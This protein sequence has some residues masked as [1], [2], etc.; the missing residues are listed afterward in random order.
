LSA[1]EQERLARQ[2]RQ[3]AQ[4]NALQPALRYGLNPRGAGI[5]DPSFVHQLVFEPAISFD[6]P[7]TR[8][9]Q[10][11]PSRTSA[12]V[13]LRPRPGLT[14]SQ[15]QAAV[16]LVRNAV[17]SR[18]FRLESS[19]YFVTGEP[20]AAL[21]V[22]DHVS[23]QLL[24]LLVA[25]ILIVTAIV[26]L[27][28]RFTRPLLPLAPAIVTVALTFGLMSL[29]GA[30]LTIASIAVL[31][32]LAG[33]AAGLAIHFQR[34]GELPLVPAAAVAIGFGVLVA[35]PVPMV[36]TFGVFVAI[37]IVLALATTLTLG[38]ALARLLPS[39]EPR[40][41]RRGKSARNLIA[42]VGAGWG[43]AVGFAGRR[44]RTVL[45]LA[46]A[47]ALL[48]WLLAPQSDV[49]SGLGKLASDDV[50]EV[51]ELD[52]LARDA[53]VERGVNVAVSADDL[54]APGVIPWMVAY[55]QKVLRRH[56]Y[57]EERPCS[58]AELCPAV[59]LKDLF[60][61]SRRRS[62]AQTRRLL[63]TLPSY[64]TQGVI[65]RDRQS[66]NISFLIRRMPVDKQQDVIAD[67]RRQL[68]PPAGVR[69]E[70]AGT[71]VL[72]ADNADFASD[73][74]ILALVALA[75]VLLMLVAFGYRRL[76][77]MRARLG[78]AVVSIAPAAM[79]AGWA[80]LIALAP[81]A[82]LNPMSATI[83][84]L[85]V[86]LCGYGTIF[87]S[88]H[89]R[90]TRT[91]GT[92]AEAAVTRAYGTGKVLLASGA[93]A[94]AGFATLIVSD[95]SM[96]DQFGALAVVTLAVVLAGAA[97]VLPSALIWAEERAP[98]DESLRKIAVALRAAP[99]RVRRLGSAVVGRLRRSRP[100]RRRGEAQR[101]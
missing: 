46:A 3:L 13:E 18:A 75:A 26:A 23:D 49:S 57:T 22:A 84:A 72:A 35:S 51:R 41:V 81:G 88:G 17:A 95:I 97:F 89:Y 94:L 71:T 24:V 15:T 37:G 43:R 9:A 45:G 10:Y 76:G 73:G 67:L 1:A 62:R 25:T 98:L 100:L 92:V 70:L 8:F 79:A 56:G 36:R 68:D 39:R 86:G 11:F 85:V 83:G 4:L 53:G 63:E 93:V 29:L 80:A 6:A 58:Q 65:A 12:V 31:P 40:A 34:T 78:A 54:T 30:E 20:V 64:F 101:P 44:P 2:A 69:A 87:L 21:G 55:Q 61:T 74:R 60:G 38:S 32:I 82:T 91:A 28:T 14:E 47:V 96:L 77:D 48:G 42:R 66:A 59:A 99:K 5:G 7:K 16:D 19:R 52:A 27:V 90:A 50:R 33:L